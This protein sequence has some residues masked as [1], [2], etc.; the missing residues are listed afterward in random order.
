MTLFLIQVF[1]TLPPTTL[2]VLSWPGYYTWAEMYVSICVCPGL[3]DDA[4]SISDSI[5]AELA[6]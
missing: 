6:V 2:H 1:L 4:S 5:G 3:H